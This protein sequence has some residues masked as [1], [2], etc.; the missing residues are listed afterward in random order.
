MVL[1]KQFSG[2]GKSAH[3]N[4]EDPK[5]SSESVLGA[6]EPPTKKKKVDGDDS[7]EESDGETRPAEEVA[8]SSTS[9]KQLGNFSYDFS[10]FTFLICSLYYLTNYDV[11]LQS[12][13]GEDKKQIKGI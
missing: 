5:L 13:E 11:I 3:D 2:K 6:D 12:D 1:S 4:L 10:I 7:D 8:E 9:D